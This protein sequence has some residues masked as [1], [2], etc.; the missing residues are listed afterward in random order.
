LCDPEQYI[1][2][3]PSDELKFVYVVPKMKICELII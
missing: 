2:L 1:I 3:N